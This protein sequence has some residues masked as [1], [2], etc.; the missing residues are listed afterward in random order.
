[1]ESAGDQHPGLTRTGVGQCQAEAGVFR[2]VAR[3]TLQKEAIRIN[4]LVE[5]KLLGNGGFGDSGPS[6][7][8][9][10]TAMRLRPSMAVG[11]AGV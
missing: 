10:R 8:A 1:M 3:A 4:T 2:G 6:G 11:D 5:E 7:V 9:K